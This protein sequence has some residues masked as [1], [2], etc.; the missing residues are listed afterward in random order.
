M[1]IARTSAP[2]M[3]VVFFMTGRS[4]PLLVLSGF[5]S[6]LAGSILLLTVMVLEVARHVDELVRWYRIRHHL[7]PLS[8]F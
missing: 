5:I 1:Q 2:R 6:C 3:A 8:A 4:L 7:V